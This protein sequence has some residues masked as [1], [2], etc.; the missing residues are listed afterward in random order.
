MKALAGREGT[1]V[2]VAGSVEKSGD[3]YLTGG[4]LELL[5]SPPRFRSIDIRV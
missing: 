4:A 1:G 5:H 2:V 3:R